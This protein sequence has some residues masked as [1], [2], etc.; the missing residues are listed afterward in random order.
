[1]LCK[2]CGKH[3]AIKYS[4]Y[5]TGE[6]CSRECAR[7]FSTKNKRVEINKKVSQKLTG[8]GHPDVEKICPTCG[9]KFTLP[10]KRK[11][12]T[13]CSVKC[14]NNDPNVVGKIS[15]SLKEHYNK[16]KNRKRLLAAGEKGRKV[17]LKNKRHGKEN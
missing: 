13:H 11:H 16:P 15:D 10:W 5:S 6:F 3:E 1:M 7:A 14:A 12:R 9:K 8:T 17:V 2:N 4:P